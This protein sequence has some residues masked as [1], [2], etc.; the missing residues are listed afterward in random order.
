M[1]M[2]IGLT[3]LLLYLAIGLVKSLADGRAHGLRSLNYRIDADA[4]EYW[5]WTRVGRLAD[6]AFKLISAAFAL[7]VGYL[8]GTGKIGE[9][10]VDGFPKSE[11]S[12]NFDFIAPAFAQGGLPAA[13]ANQALAALLIQAV[14]AAIILAFAAALLVSLLVKDKPENRRALD[15]ADSLV[16]MFGGFLV[17]VGSS[18]F[19]AK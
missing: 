10:I 2:L 6:G 9:W 8:L 14:F 4:R 13:S 3:A 5:F 15:T 1:A 19:G 18:Y 12:W 16:K 17:G 7:F 11:R